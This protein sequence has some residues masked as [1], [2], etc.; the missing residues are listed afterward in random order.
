[1]VESPMVDGVIGN[2]LCYE[3]AITSI[4][5]SDALEGLVDFEI[6]NSF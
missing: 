1:M 6:T 2:D 4:V 3:S 5:E